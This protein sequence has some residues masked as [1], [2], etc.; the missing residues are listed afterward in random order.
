MLPLTADSGT[1]A[2]SSQHVLGVMEEEVR[3]G[4]GSI[5]DSATLANSSPPAPPDLESDLHPRSP[6]SPPTTPYTDTDTAEEEEEEEEEMDVRLP[7]CVWVGNVCP[8]KTDQ[9]LTDLFRQ[10]GEFESEP[11]IFRSSR[12]AFVT[13]SRASSAH[14]AKSLEGEPF[15]EFY[16][17]PI[18][19]GWF[20]DASLL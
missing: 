9:E 4:S 8:T 14:R 7:T 1:S 16:P 18:P 19:E 11:K 6:P 15:G 13:Y 3:A 2:E 17:G 12:C 10:F 5:G 20:P